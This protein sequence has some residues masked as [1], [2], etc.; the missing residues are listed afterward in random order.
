MRI[1][2]FSDLHGGGYSEAKGLVGEHQPDWVVLLGD[3]VP[4]FYQS[5]STRRLAA[6]QGFWQQKRNCFMRAG[7]VTTSI[8]GNH[9]LP[10]FRDPELDRLPAQLEGRVVRL[11]GIPGD[12]GPFSFAKGSPDA[13]LEEELQDQLA[14]V[15]EPLIYLSHAPPWGSLDKTNRGDNIGHRPL[16]RHLQARDWP[17]AFVFCGH[18]HNAFGVEEAGATTVVNVATGYALLVWDG[19]DLRILAMDRLVQGGNFWN[20]P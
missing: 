16:F 12:S 3:M 15:P 17:A 19:D 9:E 5:P 7:T 10:G 20:S 2:L 13:V 1:L 14:R 4:D 8:L 6:Q 18:V 11:E